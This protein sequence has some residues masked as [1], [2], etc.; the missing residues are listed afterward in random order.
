MT[1]SSNGVCKHMEVVIDERGEFGLCLRGFS[2]DK[3]SLLYNSP[4]KIGNV[5]D[6]I[7]THKVDNGYFT[8]DCW[9]NI[10]ET[11]DCKHCTSPKREG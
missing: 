10:E 4:E 6:C 8:P 9:I 3:L 11:Y 1:E 2:P 7:A 5:A